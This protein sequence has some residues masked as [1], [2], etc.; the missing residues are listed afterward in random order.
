MWSGSVWVIM[1]RPPNRGSNAKGEW[2]RHPDGTLVCT[3]T[4]TTSSGQVTWTYPVAFSAAPKISATPVSSGDQRSATRGS[5]GSAS[6][7]VY[8]WTT[9]GAAWDGQIDVMAVGRWY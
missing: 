6:V 2:T 1:V 5:I 7:V 8:G 4:V 9:I 3:H